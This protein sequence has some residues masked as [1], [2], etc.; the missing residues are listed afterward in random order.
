MAGSTKF[1][2]CDVG[3]IE[4]HTLEI[5]AGQAV[6]TA[7]NLGASS[8]VSIFIN[9]VIDS[10]EAYLQDSFDG[11]NFY[12]GYNLTNEQMKWDVVGNRLYKIPPSDTASWMFFRLR[13][14]QVETEKRTIYLTARGV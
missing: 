11:E 6:S 14:N 3:K 10:D 5:P 7:I 8:I 1:G 12:D 9:G 13:V 2:K 4:Y